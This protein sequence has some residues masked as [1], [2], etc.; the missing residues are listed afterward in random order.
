MLFV[1]DDSINTCFRPDW[2]GGEGR[3][4]FYDLVYG[5]GF[6]LTCI[7]IYYALVTS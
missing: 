5:T 3:V 2:Y 1:N 7:F 4:N 6:V